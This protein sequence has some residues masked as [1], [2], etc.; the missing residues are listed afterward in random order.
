MKQILLASALW[1]TLWTAQAAT[2]SVTLQ[3]SQGTLS[4]IIQ[5]PTPK[6]GKT[7]PMVILMHGS[8]ARQEGPIFEG[9]AD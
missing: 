9:I 3:G 5:K 7:C 2:E 4:A 1:F 6:E 8:R